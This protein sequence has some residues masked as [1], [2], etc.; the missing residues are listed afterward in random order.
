[1]ERNVKL[2]FNPHAD[3]GQSWKTA[4]ALQAVIELQGGAS[5][6]STE[7]PGHATELASKA[8]EEGFNVV[9][10]LGGDGT[11]HEVINGLMKIP[12]NARPL[13]G[14]VPLGSGN[15]FGKNIGIQCDP[16]QAMLRVFLGD[17]RSVDI[18]VIRDNTGREEYWN[19]TLGIGF[20]ASVVF[21]TNKITRLQGF[22]MYLWAVIQTIILHHDVAHMTIVTDR[23]TIDQEILMITLCN[24]PREGGGFNVAPDAKPNDGILDY[25]LISDVSRLMMFRLIPEVLNGTHGRFKQV[26]M[27]Q[28]QRIHIDYNRPMAIHTDGEIFT[29]FTSDVSEVSIE[30]MP[31]E[32]NVI[33]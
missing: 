22:A 30:V 4:S 32:I 21:Q 31:D 18:G 19:N 1:M 23:E 10:A 16:E 24:G 33:F 11:V 20:D 26:R 7:Y 8:V 29:S 6:A 9:A 25:A 14:I 17:P 5:W 28:F 2:I 13:L 27:G 3:K 12:Q 15:D